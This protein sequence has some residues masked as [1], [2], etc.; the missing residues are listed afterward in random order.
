MQTYLTCA[1]CGTVIS[2]DDQ[3]IYASITTRMEYC[4]E[5]LADI[6]RA[7]LFKP[8][9]IGGKREDEKPLKEFECPQC[10]T[11]LKVPSKRESKSYVTKCTSCDWKADNTAI[12]K[13]VY[14]HRKGIIY[15][16]R[17]ECFHCACWIAIPKFVKPLP[18]GYFSLK[19]P[20]CSK[21]FSTARW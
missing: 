12:S 11:L 7:T 4:P 17:V 13:A 5:C 16:Y 19:C 8:P 20:F 15:R 9:Y 18:T 6:V 21:W 1:D 10:F 3:E 2:Q 14:V